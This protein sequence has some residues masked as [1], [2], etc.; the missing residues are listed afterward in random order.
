MKK[1][2]YLLLAIIVIAPPQ[3][4]G[5]VFKIGEQRGEWATISD[6]IIETV[7][8]PGEAYLRLYADGYRLGSW[9]ISFEINLVGQLGDEVYGELRLSVPEL[10]VEVVYTETHVYNG[11]DMDRIENTLALYIGGEEVYSLHDS[12]VEPFDSRLR[13]STRPS[14]HMTARRSHSS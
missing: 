3:A 5:D 4:M 12:A 6:F 9:V 10:G 2:L 14:C 8:S 1:I 7:P 11:L 13:Y